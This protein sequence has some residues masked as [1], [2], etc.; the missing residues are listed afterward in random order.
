MLDI[1][2]KPDIIA[3]ADLGGEGNSKMKALYTQ[4]YLPNLDEY[5][6]TQSTTAHYFLADLATTRGL[7]FLIKQPSQAKDGIQINEPIAYHIYAEGEEPKNIIMVQSFDAVYIQIG[8]MFYLSGVETIMGQIDVKFTTNI[9]K[10]MNIASN[11]Q[12]IY[13]SLG[14]TLTKVSDMKLIYIVNN[15]EAINGNSG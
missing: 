15:R 14:S 8:D 12:D 5:V 2:Q 11:F 3:L 1:Q 13:T 4:F 7:N 9:D 10:A 6:I